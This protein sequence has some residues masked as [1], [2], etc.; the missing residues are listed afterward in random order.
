MKI[1]IDELLTTFAHTID[2]APNQHL[3]QSTQ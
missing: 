2:T 1:Q 3:L